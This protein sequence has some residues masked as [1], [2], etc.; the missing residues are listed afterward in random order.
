MYHKIGQLGVPRQDAGSPALARATV[1]LCLSSQI[2]ELKRQYDKLI[3]EVGVGFCRVGLLSAFR[4]GWSRVARESMADLGPS[5]GKAG[6]QDQ[7]LKVECW[8]GGMLADF[9]DVHVHI[10]FG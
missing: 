3:Q 6:T 10:A 4:Q 1:L 5:G 2:A 9:Q 8:L 7:A